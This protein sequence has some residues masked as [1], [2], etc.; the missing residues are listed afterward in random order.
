MAVSKNWQALKFVPLA[1]RTIAVCSAALRG[2]KTEACFALI[3][4][5]I[6]QIAKRR[7][8]CYDY[9]APFARVIS[10]IYKKV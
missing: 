8:G 6:R 4:E 9:H 2:S 3:P 7:A 1:Q 10:S 5:K